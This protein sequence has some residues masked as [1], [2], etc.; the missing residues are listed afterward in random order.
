MAATTPKQ[1]DDLISSKDLMSEAGLSRATLN[2]YIAQGILPR[3]AV[4]PPV[5][6]DASLRHAPRVG[7]FPKSVL[8]ILDAVGEMK[9][10]GLSMAEIAATL[11]AVAASSHDGPPNAS[12]APPTP[13]GPVTIS[14]DQVEHPAYLV[15]SRF[16]LEW[17]NDAARALFFSG[18]EGLSRDISERSLFTLLFEGGAE[19]GLSGLADRDEIIRFHLAIAKNR[20]SKGALMALDTGGIDDQDLDVIARLYDEAAPTERG[21][22]QHADVNLTT[23]HEEDDW[24]T[25]YASFFR[26]GIFFAYAPSGNDSESLMSLLARRDIV[27]RD[28]LKKREPHLTPLAVLVADIQESVKICAELPPEEYFELIND[29]WSAMEPKL[30]R[31]YA[32]HGKHVGDGMVYYFFPQPDCNYVLNA[33]RCAEEMRTEMATISKRWQKRKNWTNV[34]K[35]NIGLAEGREWF[36]AYQTPTHLEFTALGDTINMAG[37]LSDFARGGTTWATKDMLG[38]LSTKERSALHYGVRRTTEDG[39]EML[40]AETFSRISNLLDLDDAQNIKFRDI[41]ALAVTEVLSVEMDET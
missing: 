11:K 27:I 29:V 5:S 35:L 22:L 26:E 7:Y 3:P 13:M 12:L 30:R 31:Y 19:N 17:A 20:I 10:Q 8:G 2:N 15:N 23:S 39:T 25:L 24:H 37:R 40:A 28:L 9:D 16:E 41:S 14:L 33:L 34:L 18:S 38:E 21:P 4:R 1:D 36:G 32:T 6:H